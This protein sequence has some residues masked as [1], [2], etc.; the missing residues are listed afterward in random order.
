MSYRI[1]KQDLECQVASINN[2]FKLPHKPYKCKDGKWTP[3][4]GVYHLSWAYGGVALHKM[5][6]TPGCTGVEDVFRCGH[7]SKK[8]LHNRMHAYIEGLRD[9]EWYEVTKREAVNS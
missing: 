7:V 5:S 3:N 2:H 8:E 9:S 4:A 6:K 1:N